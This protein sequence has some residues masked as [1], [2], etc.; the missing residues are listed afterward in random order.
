MRQTISRGIQAGGS[1]YHGCRITCLLALSLV[2]VSRAADESAFERDVRRTLVTRCHQCHDASEASAG[3]EFESLTSPEAAMNRYRMW[4]KVVEQVSSAM[5]PPQGETPLTAD[6]KQRL[7]AWITR[8]FDTSQRPDPG[9]PLVRQLTREEYSQTMRDLLKFWH[10]SAGQAGIPHESVVDGF[11]NRAGGQVLESSLMERYFTAADISL[12]KLFLEGGTGGQRRD[13]GI[14]GDVAELAAAWQKHLSTRDQPEAQPEPVSDEAVPHLAARQV[15]HRFMRRAFRR[16]VTNDE[17]ERY[18]RIAD[19]ALDSGDDFA[20]SLRKAMKPVL[21]SPYFLLRVEQNPSEPGRVGRVSDHE[22]AV[23]LSYF[24]WGSMPDDELFAIADQGKLS[25]PDVLEQQVRRMFGH[26][27]GEALTRH[28]LTKWLQL[29][30][31]HKSLP[32]QNVFPTFTRSL[33]DSMERETWMFCNNL[34]KEDRSVLEL[35]DADYT[36]VNEELGRHYGISDLPSKDF[37]KV[38]LRPEHHRGGLPGMASMLTMT[39]HTDRTKPTARGKWILEVLLG[40]PPPP[41][42]A[43]AGSFS[44]PDKDR[45]EPES[46]REKLGQHASNPNCVACHLRVDP[47]GFALENYNA[48]GAWR[49]DVGGKPVD[50]KGTLPGIGDFQGVDGLRHVL[51]S[52]QPQFVRNLVEQTLSYALGRDVSY[53]DEQSINAIVAAL[54]QDDYRYSRL[55]LEVTK[56]FPFQ[57]RRAVLDFVETGSHSAER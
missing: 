4:K 30:Q 55:I 43:N 45:P 28:F 36:F 34:R 9:P 50:N 6:E 17:A 12:D 27:R 22:L 7:L 44:P 20:A 47:L 54:E 51:K 2:S 40:S 13:I 14:S 19:T 41:P 23:R 48:I 46:F 25:E 56:S 3:I 8:A 38:S 42:P 35:L 32:Q 49:D 10:D 29:P 39:S 1:F 57:H 33:R 11:A 18:A 53:Y 15:L 5:M 16:P 52:K 24:L 21:V 37:A 31:I 26:H